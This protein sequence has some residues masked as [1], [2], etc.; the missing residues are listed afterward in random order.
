[1]TSPSLNSSCSLNSSALELSVA[2][3]AWAYGWAISRQVQAPVERPGYFQILVGKPGQTTRYVLPHFDQRLIQR[4]VSAESGPGTWLKICSPIAAVSPLLASSWAIHEPEFLMSTVLAGSDAPAIGGYR[5]HT[6]R[7]GALAF[8]KI[9]AET[10]EIAASGQVAI[11]DSF[12]CFD[13][14]V[15]AEAHR[16]RGLG[17]H[18]MTALTN[19][20][21][22]LGARHGVLVAT[23]A[24]AAL[25]NAVGW[26][27]VSPV[28]AASCSS[29][30]TGSAGDA[31]PLDGLPR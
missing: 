13:Q 3:R 30:R 11:D 8:A 25:Y 29:L 10:G 6:D 24:G 14:I 2:T 19:L 28:T 22:D 26:S 23:E 20:S 18:L 4:L 7:S 17:R 21:L 12:A 31:E 1:M 5:V 16:R 15:T 9:V 27:M